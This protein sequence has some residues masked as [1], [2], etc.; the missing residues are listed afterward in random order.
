MLG[1]THS[2]IRRGPKMSLR[3]EYLEGDLPRRPNDPIVCGILPEADVA[4]GEFW[5]DFSDVQRIKRKGNVLVHLRLKKGLG[6]KFTYSRFVFLIEVLA[7]H[8][9]SFSLFHFGP[10]LTFC[11]E[12]L[13]QH[14]YIV[15]TG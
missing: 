7:M 14:Y 3:T 12:F 15:Q 10:D 1:N 4:I 11:T 8:P 6:Y 5:V 9:S 2:S 13:A